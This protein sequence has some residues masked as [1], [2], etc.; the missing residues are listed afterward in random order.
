MAASHIAIA[1]IERAAGCCD[2]GPRHPANDRPDRP[3][4][5]QAITLTLTVQ[6]RETGKPVTE[7]DAQLGTLID[8][9]LETMYAAPGIGLAATQVDVHRRVIV[10][11]VSDTSNAAVDVA[12]AEFTQQR[13]E[14][15]L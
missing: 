6:D 12:D 11:D 13:L 7:F 9:R 10:I 4:V 15:G 5:G 1:G 2:H 8:D 14:R 3:A